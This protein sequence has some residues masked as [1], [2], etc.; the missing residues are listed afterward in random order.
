MNT[1]TA[2]QRG[3]SSPLLL[4]GLLLL[5]GLGTTVWWVARHAGA[6]AGAVDPVWDREAC[7]HCRMHVSE[8]GFAAQLHTPDG[9]VLFFD[10]PGCLFAYLDEHPALHPTHMWFHHVR[11]PRWIPADRVRFV[12]VSPTP[13][14]YGLGA[15]D[16]PEP[17]S[18]TLEQARER[19][20]NREWARRETDRAEDRP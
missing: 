11:E 8:P 4:F 1:Q 19:V 2:R 18:L 10:D 5:V 17:G 15:V 6:P 12:R 9:E 14:G 16:R 3:G 7:A 13:M 20:R